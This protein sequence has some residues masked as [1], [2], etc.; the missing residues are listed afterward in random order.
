MWA[1]FCVLQ[2][3]HSLLLHLSTGIQKLINKTVMN[4]RTAHRRWT[5]CKLLDCRH[6]SALDFYTCGVWTVTTRVTHKVIEWY[7]LA[8]LQ[9]NV[10]RMWE[11][12]TNKIYTPERIYKR[13]LS[14]WDPGNWIQLCHWGASWRTTPKNTQVNLSLSH[15]ISIWYGTDTKYSLWHIWNSNLSK[16]LMFFMDVLHD[17]TVQHLN[18][19]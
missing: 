9:E 17:K 10:S 19:P 7:N 6:H 18:L 15:F 14:I 2:R 3:L 5:R 1:P 13:E 12:S 4:M 16:H 11:L 8:L